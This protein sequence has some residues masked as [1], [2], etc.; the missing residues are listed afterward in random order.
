MQFNVCP[1]ILNAS[2]GL[3]VSYT[4]LANRQQ[5]RLN[6]FIRFPQ[7]SLIIYLAILSRTAKVNPAT[8]QLMHG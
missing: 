5:S 2:S 4:D 7:L 1:S 6:S 3:H 8:L